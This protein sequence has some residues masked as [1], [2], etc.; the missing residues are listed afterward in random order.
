MTMM[1]RYMEKNAAKQNDITG[2]AQ[3]GVF[4]AVLM[5]VQ[6]MGMPNLV[7][8]T[9]VNSILIFTSLR[10]G[11]RYAL[12]LATLS[13]VGG[14]IA[15]HLP[16]PLYPVAPVIVCG[17]Y[18]LVFLYRLLLRHHIIVRFFIP[19]LVKGAFIGLAGMIIVNILDIGAS[20]KWLLAPVLGLQFITALAGILTGEK[21]FEKIDSQKFKELQNGLN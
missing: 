6:L 9:L 18:F 8:G 2:P 14:M 15:G 16:A 4:L 10:L 1:G 17:N 7:T 20:V 21:L 5:A 3:A 19:A 13:P 12:M 11:L